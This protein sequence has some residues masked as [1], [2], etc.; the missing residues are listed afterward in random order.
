MSD[1]ILSDATKAQLKRTGTASIATQLYKR[2]LRNQFIQG[3]VPVSPKAE[4]MVGQAFTLRY[5][6]AR[7]DRNQLDVFRNADHPQRV[8]VETCPEGHVLVMD[9]RQDSTAATAGSILITR[10][11]VRGCAGV[12]TD[13]GLRDAAGIGALDMP[14]FHARASAPTNLTK[15]EALDINVPIGC[16]GV[17]VFPGDVI[18]GDGDGV[19]VIPA[20]LAD[21]IAEVCAG[22][23]AFEDFVL[24]EVLAG[25]PI[26]GLYPC[27][28]EEN[29]K[30]FDAWR[31]KTG[32]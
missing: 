29:Q 21:E 32:R 15:H 9:A 17:A 16:G 20:H 13:G 22:M 5:I 8:A 7:E 23:E 19:M 24:E 18:V 2:G 28:L 25:A 30:K 6:P 27:T 26:I 11:A 12:V 1:Y 3:V 31:V 10:M 14:A 4:R